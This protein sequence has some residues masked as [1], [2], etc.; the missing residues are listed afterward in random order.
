[1]EFTQI[2]GSLATILSI[3]TY[4]PQVVQLYKTKLA[5][6]ISMS[7]LFLLSFGVGIWLVFGIRLGDVPL[8]LPIH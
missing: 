8:I 7:M 2:R 6:D 5:R 4:M 3:V 1:M